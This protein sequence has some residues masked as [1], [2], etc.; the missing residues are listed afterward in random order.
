MRDFHYNPLSIN[1]M[2][3]GIDECVS[4]SINFS[5]KNY[6][7]NFPEEPFPNDVKLVGNTIK[8]KKMP[9]YIAQFL[10]K[11]IRLLLQ[12]RGQDFLNEYYSYIEK[13]YNYRIPLRSIA[14]K[15]KIKKSIN[16]YIEDCKTVTKA[17]NPKSRQAWMELALSENLNIHMG[18]T[19]YYINIGTSKSHSDI[20]RVTHYYAVDGLYGEKSDR[21]VALEREWKRDASDGKMA[22][23]GQSL[24]FKEYVRKHHPEI[25]IEDEVVLNCRLIPESVINSET[26]T[27]CKE[28]E[29]YNV[30]KYISQFN[31]R[32]K[33]LLVC[34]RPEIRQRILIDSPD[35]RPYFT[36]EECELC[37]GLPNKPSDQDTYEELMT[38]ED[39]EIAFWLRHPEWEI[40]YLKECGMDW[41]KIVSDYKERKRREEELGISEIRKAFSDILYSM[42]SSDF[43]KF[44]EGI[45]PSAMTKIVEMDPVTGAFMAKKFPDVRI[46]T[47]HDILDAEEDYYNSVE[48]NID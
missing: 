13:I 40:P 35:K 29:E 26:D 18:E 15:G 23:E 19:L 39:K 14:S 1:K 25:L 12:K 24:K 3:L 11:G 31:N 8:S 44:E 47:I 27:F 32:I 30:P 34:F 10:A 7:D 5:R 45:L 36:E 41:D 17:G 6:A 2:G 20:K 4:S 28:G 42:D 43:E 37:S 21:R 16:E 48:S 46:G 22:P 9:E 33:P 38:M